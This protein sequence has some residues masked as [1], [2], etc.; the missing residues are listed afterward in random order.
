MLGY[1]YLSFVL[2]AIYM[3]CK[4]VALGVMVLGVMVLGVFGLWVLLFCSFW[5]FYYWT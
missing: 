2:L 3:H 1:E 5:S 4:F